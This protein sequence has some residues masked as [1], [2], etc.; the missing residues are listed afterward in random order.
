MTDRQ[1]QTTSETGL[2]HET[3][4]MRLWHKAKKLGT[5][6]PQDI[7]FT[8]DREDWAQFDEL[9]REVM[10]HL[11]AEFLGGEES[12]TNDLLPLIQTV[13]GE[14]RLEEE[15]Y[16][17]SFLFEEAKHVESF[18]RFLDE[19]ADVHTDLSRF[20][21][22]NYQQIFGDKLPTAL[23]AL[24]ED[25]SPQNQ[26]IA[27]VTYNMIVE[28]VLAETGYYA[29]HSMLE[30]QDLL[31]G[32]REIA[33][34][35]KQDESRH[36]AFGVYFLS[37]LTAEHGDEVWETIEGRMNEMLPLA[38]GM[39]NETFEQ[40]DELPFGLE[41]DTFVEYATQ[42]FQKRYARIAKARTETVD[43]LNDDKDS[44]NGAAAE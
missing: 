9:E 38:I 23:N 14:G 5:W 30:E 18:R 41:L 15:M 6:D 28:G 12:V 40:Y 1:F 17:T 22:E 31:P 3:V 7:D 26:A 11:T 42:Q 13:A 37:R 25:P 4:P 34:L 32:M 24:R 39:I 8:R 33:G 43:D 27:S 20:H 29:F 44:F 36:L 19:V 16:L 21:G 10:L 2:D 35:L